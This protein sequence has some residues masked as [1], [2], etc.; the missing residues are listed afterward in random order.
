M[1]LSHLS[2]LFRCGRIEM[3]YRWGFPTDDLLTFTFIY[4]KV[5]AFC[6]LDISGAQAAQASFLHEYKRLK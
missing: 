3:F 4:C 5:L 1:Q 6:E 2:L